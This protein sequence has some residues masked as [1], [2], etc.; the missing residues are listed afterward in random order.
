MT[1]SI[2]TRRLSQE[3]KVI[4]MTLEQLERIGETMAILRHPD[5]VLV[6]E[7]SPDATRVVTGAADKTARVWDAETGNEL[8]S[9]T[10]S[11]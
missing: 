8:L 6:V 4:T 1:V 2:E 11:R 9:L 7:F 5:R 10:G 3:N